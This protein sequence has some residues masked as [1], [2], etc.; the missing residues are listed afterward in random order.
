MKHRLYVR[1]PL[2]ADQP[3][4]LDRDRAHYLTRVLR[5]RRG[6]RLVCFDGSGCAWEASLLEATPRTAV[7]AIGPVIAEE[8]P[9]SPQLHLVQG[10]LKGASMDAVVQKSTELGAT[11]LWLIRAE[12]SNA[13]T[14]AERSARKL[15]H[16]Q[17]VV[18]SAAEQCGALHLPRLHP[19]RDLQAF[20]ATPPSATL[21]MLDPG[22]EPLPLSV[23]RAAVALLI[24]PEGG[25][26]DG[27]RQAA[28]AAGAS[29]YG[30]G[31]RVLRAETAPLAALAALRHGWGWG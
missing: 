21:M 14:D 13:A 22:A 2:A 20:L 5:L 1:G 7:L 10:L 27:E 15:E 6:E 17:R 29:R 25:W 18:E 4:T 26:S 31:A 9:P 28:L 3:L 8:P 19:L 11:D 30:L 23:P 24:G 16:W 12:R